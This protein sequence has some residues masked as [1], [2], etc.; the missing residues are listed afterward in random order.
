MASD[1]QKNT[2]KKKIRINIA[3]KVEMSYNIIMFTNSFNRFFLRFFPTPKIFSVPAF[4]LDISD[5]SIKFMELIM[6]KNGIRVGKYG[7]RVSPPGVVES[8]RI[9]NSKRMEEILSALRKEEKIKYAIRQFSKTFGILKYVR[10]DK[11]TNLFPED[12]K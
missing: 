3:R 12:L 1:F 2:E 11:D 8:G 7:E 6:T 5:E 9:K 4:G 10:L